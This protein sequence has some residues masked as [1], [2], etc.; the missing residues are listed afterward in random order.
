MQVRVV[1]CECVPIGVLLV[2]HGIFP[3]SPIRPRLGIS[4]DILDLY[5]A[6]FER[7]CDAITALA[8]AL[9]TIYNRRGF[10][11]VSER[12]YTGCSMVQQPQRSGREAVIGALRSA[13]RLLF[14]PA[15]PTTP[16]APAAPAVPAAPAAPS[17]PT[18]PTATSARTSAGSAP[19][20]SAPAPALTP[21]RADPI[22]RERC[23]ACFG[24]AEWGRSL[25]DGGDVQL[26]ADG[27][28]SYR[29][30]RSAGDGPIGYDPSL[31]VPQHKIDAVARRIAEAREHRN[32]DILPSLPDEVIDVCQATFEAANEKSR[33]A[34]SNDTMP[35]ILFL[36]NIYTPGEQQ[37]YIIALLEELQSLLPPQATI[38]Q[39]YDIGCVVDHSVKLYPILS[40]SFRERLAFIINHL[41]SYKHEWGCQ[42]IFSPRF[43]Q[44]ANL[45]DHE[46]VERVWSRMRKM[47][48]L[49]RSQWASRR[50]WMIDRFGMF[51]NEENQENLGAWI[52]RQQN[53][54]ERKHRSSV[55]TLRECR[56]PEAELRNQ[57]RD[58]KQAQSS[59]RSYAPVRVRRQIDKVVT[60]QTQINGVEKTIADVKL[61]ISNSSDSTGSLSLLRNLR[62]THEKLSQEADELYA[63]LNVCGAFPELG[64]LP[65]PFAH[66]LLM[67]HN[68]KGVIRKRAIAS[69]QEWEELDRAVGGRRE[70]LGTKMY[71][72][73]RHAISKRQPALLKLI[74]KFNEYCAKLEAICPVGCQVP[75]PS[76]LPTQLA[77]LR[78]D[79]TL[80]EDVWIFADQSD[81][82]RWLNDE[83]VRD[84]VQSLHLLDRCAEESRRLDLERAN[85][86]QWLEDELAIVAQAITSNSDTSFAF[87]LEQR[88]IYL[89]HLKYHWA[90]HLRSPSFRPDPL[91]TQPPQPPQPPHTQLPHSTHR[92]NT[93]IVPPNPRGVPDV[94]MEV[95]LAP[96]AEAAAAAEE[97]EAAAEE[98]EVEDVEQDFEQDFAESDAHADVDP[99][100]IADPE[101]ALD[102]VRQAEEDEEEESSGLD[103][104][105]RMAVEIKWDHQ[106]Q[107]T[108]DRSLLRDLREHNS[109][110]HIVMERLSHFV[111]RNGRPNMEIEPQDL[112]RFLSPTGRLNGFGLNGVAA[113]LHKT[114]SSP[115]SSLHT[116]SATQCAILSSYDLPRVRYKASDE[117]LWRSLSPTQYW[118]KCLWLLP[119]HR[120]VEEH[121]VLAIIDIPRQ[122]LH[123]FD[124]LAS[125]RHW[126]RD[127]RDIMTLVTRMV[128]LSNRKGHSLPVSTAEEPW[129]AYPMFEV[130]H[131]K[132]TN[133]YDCGVWVLSVM[134]AAMRGFG[135]AEIYEGDIPALRELL[136]NHV[137]ALPIT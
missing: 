119:I 74:G 63:S 101:D 42:L 20:A 10:T 85:L 97:E 37:R 44:G 137:R 81:I 89:E 99:G 45:A 35:A 29:H 11:V 36:A 3:A 15:A 38:L 133:G 40:V 18:A 70:P 16:T 27:C 43:C 84:G 72:A 111:I 5:R 115:Y 71:Q 106:S 59:I 39:A 120:P 130:N 122:R 94:D 9:H 50:I 100:T 54:M 88:E 128:V 104:A 24:H 32:A 34:D 1:T 41:H 73:T 64:N 26:G 69:F 30:L 131:P 52:E 108:P 47:V 136:A 112:D 14:P 22:L 87:F 129:A 124:S 46:D 109:G 114:F 60:L 21:G 48:P 19:S 80:H 92:P 134:A 65:R 86:R 17:A 57:W 4:F 127:L 55:R 96:E 79:P 58:Q 91:H 31:F 103:D 13:E 132:Q 51:L 113:S 105:D 83:D 8:A 102:L 118:E 12:P 78:N 123:F 90:S 107:N 93:R 23:P 82:P 117:E 53:K 25:V 49:T 126:R 2:R 67:V 121:W 66:L 62:S 76:A 116:N 28:F 75:I 98:L 135:G 110:G 125:S 68:L 6:L 95:A 61:V 77:T 33:R 56:V 7:S